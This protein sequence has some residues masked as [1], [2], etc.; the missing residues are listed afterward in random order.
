MLEV[1]VHWETAPVDAW[2]NLSK[3]DDRACGRR[4]GSALL[5]TEAS[6]ALLAVA[7]KTRHG[8]GD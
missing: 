2:G 5:N 4:G 7:A 1:A 3:V 6:L 8:G